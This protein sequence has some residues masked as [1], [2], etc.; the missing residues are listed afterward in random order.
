VGQAEAEGYTK[1]WDA[2]GVAI[3]NLLEFQKQHPKAKLRILCLTDG[4]DTVR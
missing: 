1:L 3:S 2:C 4:D